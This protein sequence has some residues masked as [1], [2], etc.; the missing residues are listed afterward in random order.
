MAFF[1][2]LEFSTSVYAFLAEKMSVIRS[3]VILWSVKVLLAGGALS[4]AGPGSLGCFPVTN[5]IGE[6]PFTFVKQFLA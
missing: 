2:L 5:W 4:W 6:K 1:S 3:C